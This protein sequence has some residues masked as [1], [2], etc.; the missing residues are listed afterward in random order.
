MN[1]IRLLLT[2]LVAAL[3]LPLAASAA[4]KV[5]GE[6]SVAATSVYTFR[7]TRLTGQSL[8][9]SVNLTLGNAYA[10]IW[11]N[12]PIAREADPEVDFTVGLN[13][14]AGPLDVDVGL[15]AY[16]YPGGSA[17]TWEPYVTVSKDVSGFAL[18]ATGFYD[19]T[20]KARTYQLGLSRD[21]SVTKRLTL[22]PRVTAGI[23][24]AAGD[25]TTYYEGAVEAAV[26][27][28]KRATL[29]GAAAY[30]STDDRSI[31]RGIRSYTAGVRVSF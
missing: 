28:N 26:T 7:G 15:T 14:S 10:T 22:K 8:Q 30:T 2:A 17:T 19:V 29:F 23:T 5:E 13:G 24:R 9:P 18:A 11:A 3:T 6:V 31:E 21:I 4:T 12:Q 16:R 20:L 27:L 25:S 1:R